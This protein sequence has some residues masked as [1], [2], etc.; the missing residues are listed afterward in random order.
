MRKIILILISIFL[1][2]GCTKP[3]TYTIKGKIINGDMNQPYAGVHFTLC[4]QTS[5]GIL[6]KGE[7]TTH[8]EYTTD[9]DGN[10][11]CSYT[12]DNKNEYVFFT[13]GSL[14]YGY[15]VCMNSAS[16]K[17]N[18]NEDKNVYVAKYGWVR[19]FLHTTKPPTIN[20]TLHI[21]I[22]GITGKRIDLTN[23]KEGLNDSVKMSMPEFLCV[24]G[25]TIAEY[26]ESLSRLDKN[27]LANQ[28]LKGNPFVTDIT[29]NY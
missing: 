16:F 3:K 18:A 14:P 1:I 10:F 25:R 9:K 21:W 6:A 26:N 11:S 13:F 8:G 12:G 28:K 23:L 4:S 5:S 19:F 22:A 2:V 29:I 15:N 7:L 24:W 20:D 27:R 17:V